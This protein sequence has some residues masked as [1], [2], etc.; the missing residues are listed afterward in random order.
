[1]NGRTIS[2]VAAI[3]ACLVL[4]AVSYGDLFTQNALQGK[5]TGKEDHSITLPEA[6]KLTSNYQEK[7]VSGAAIGGYFGK[8][9]VEAILQQEGVVGLRYYFGLNEDG[10]QCMVLVGV[11]SQ[12]DDLVE[13]VL[14]ERSWMCPPFCSSVNELNTPQVSYSTNF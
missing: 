8:E 6:S 10:S 7:Q 13:G 11:N 12:G 5:Y 4:I 3:I 9:A 14:A 1:M 2:V